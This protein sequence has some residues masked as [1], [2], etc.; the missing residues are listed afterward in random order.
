M[1]DGA[2]P[3]LPRMQQPGLTLA[4]A[5]AGALSFWVADVFVHVVAGRAFN[6]SHARSITFILPI[7]FAIAYASLRKFAAHRGYKSLGIA[8]LAGVWL[9]GGLFMM[10][11]ATASGGGFASANGV[12]GSL[13]AIALSVIPPVTYMLATY[14]DSLFALLA[15]T[16]GALL[17]WSIG[18]NGT[19]LPFLRRSR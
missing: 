10:I 8:M 13:V 5:A 16:V 18:R 15:V 17:M 1:Q 7:A 4:F 19:P 6:S 9:A 3:L 14:D 12:R 11:A 2:S